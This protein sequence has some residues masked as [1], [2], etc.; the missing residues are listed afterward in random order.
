MITF[1][2]TPENYEKEKSGKKANTE[3]IMKSIDD[4]RHA[5]LLKMINTQIYDKIQI[6][7]TESDDS[8]IRQITDVTFWNGIWIIS[9][10]SHEGRIDSKKVFAEWLHDTYEEL[11]KVYKWKTQKKCRVKFKDLP[12]ANKQVILN[13]A[14]AI[15]KR[16]CG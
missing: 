5:K 4:S 15:K 10:D 13:F 6:V 2:S 12:E 3:R 11:S 14:D 8:F 16:F 9:W 1:K 7:N